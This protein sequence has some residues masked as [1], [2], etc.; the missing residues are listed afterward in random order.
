MTWLTRAL[1]ISQGSQLSGG[2]LIFSERLQGT[3]AG[4]VTPHSREDGGLEAMRS[5]RNVPSIPFHSIQ[6]GF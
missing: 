5:Y 4:Q 2:V 6:A 3:P 1:L